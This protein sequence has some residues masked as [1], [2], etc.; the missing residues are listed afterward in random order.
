MATA[1]ERA[2]L[3]IQNDT[4]Y[5]PTDEDIQVGRMMPGQVEKASPVQLNRDLSDNI[6]LII[7]DL[8]QKPDTARLID[9]LQT[10]SNLPVNENPKQ[11]LSELHK[12]IK[13]ADLSEKI[14]KDMSVM[15]NSFAEKGSMNKRN[16]TAWE[17]GINKIQKLCDKKIDKQTKSRMQ[18]FR[19]KVSRVRDK[20]KQQAKDTPTP[21]GPSR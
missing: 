4:V 13:K 7:G 15:M 2:Y 18:R 3:N 1:A 10:V 19:D 14:L 6:N 11:A 8:S 9:K 20:E 21:R 16:H 12:E 17:R 5:Y